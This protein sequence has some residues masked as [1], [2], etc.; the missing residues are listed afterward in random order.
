MYDTRGLI[1]VEHRSCASRLVAVGWPLRRAALNLEA[2]TEARTPCAFPAHPA[3]L[4]RST[5]LC[6]VAVWPS[7]SDG[8]L[9]VRG[10]GG[11]TLNH[12][13]GMCLP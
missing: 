6:S 5:M 13:G 10:D 11:M 3:H 4:T 1:A 2:R 9:R 7:L 12:A 8:R